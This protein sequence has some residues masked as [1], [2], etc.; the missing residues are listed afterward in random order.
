MFPSVL[1]VAL[2]GALETVLAAWR[3][4]MARLACDGAG[5]RVVAEVA[6]FVLPAKGVV[7]TEVRLADAV[8]VENDVAVIVFTIVV[9]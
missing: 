6:G 2:P 9:G 5:R 8:N 7:M 1:E 4:E 3:G